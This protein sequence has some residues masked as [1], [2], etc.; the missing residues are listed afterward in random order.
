VL[1]N[2]IQLFS[3]KPPQTYE[4]AFVERVT[5]SDKL[6]R[7]RRVEQLLMAGWALIVLKSIL[8]TWAVHRWHVPFSPLW[9]ILPTVMFGALVTAVYLWRE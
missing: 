9:I 7:N 6:P 8:V 2:L 5:V 3:R 1:A 4:N